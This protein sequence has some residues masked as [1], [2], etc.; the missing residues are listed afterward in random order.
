MNMEKGK[1]IKIASD[2]ENFWANE[3]Q[4][5]FANKNK[6]I[7]YVDEKLAKNKIDSEAELIKISRNLDVLYYR[8]SESLY[9]KKSGRD[10]EMIL[11]GVADILKIYAGG[12]IYFTKADSGQKIKLSD[13]IDDDMREADAAMGEPAYPYL[14]RAETFPSYMAGE[15]AAENNRKLAIYNSKRAA[16]NAKLAREELRNKLNGL[17][18]TIGDQLA[19]SLWYYD[20]KQALIVSGGYIG[21]ECL[22]EQSPAIVFRKKAANDKPSGKVKLSEVASLPDVLE[23]LSNVRN[24]AT[25]A[26]A[27]LK[28]KVSDAKLAGAAAFAINSGKIV[29]FVG[30]EKGSLYQLAI[31]GDSIGDAVKLADDV[32]K[33]GKWFAGENLVYLRGDRGDLYVNENL[34]DSDVSLP[35][36]ERA[37]SAVGS[38]EVFYYTNWKNSAGS[39]K[40]YDGQ[41]ARKIADEA[42]DFHLLGDRRAVYLGNY[43]N[44][45][46]KGD[47]F[48]CEIGETPPRGKPPIKI[49]VGVTAVLAPQT[50][51]GGNDVDGRI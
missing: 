21:A 18:I 22:G 50:F 29:F 31:D 7:Y 9:R 8:K 4:A 17:E 28:G 48:L 43:D 12:E 14:T 51:K 35:A 16:Y 32:L 30:G 49:A 39:L 5:V 26:K 11:S 15:I 44:K 45:S 42:H 34:A 37:Y 3:R 36:M 40:V 33:S 38:K 46:Q 10:R 27:A 13:F 47:L 41:K 2:V 6:D 1:E 24:A 20:G 23:R 25:E 19:K